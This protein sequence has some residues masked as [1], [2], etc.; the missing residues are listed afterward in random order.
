MKIDLDDCGCEGNERKA[1]EL[2]S[3]AFFLPVLKT[4]LTVA[5]PVFY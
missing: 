1:R 5:A 3:K 2:F 4:F